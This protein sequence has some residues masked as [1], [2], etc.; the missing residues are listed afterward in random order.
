MANKVLAPLQ[1]TPAADGFAQC[2]LVLQDISSNLGL[3]ANLAYQLSLQ[4]GNQFIGNPSLAAS[5]AQGSIIQGDPR[6][7]PQLLAKGVVIDGSLATKQAL[8][9]V[10]TGFSCL[11]TL[12]IL[13]GA[14][15]S[16]ATLSI[17]FGF[18]AGATDVIA[19]AV[20]AGLTGPTLAK[21]L[22]PIAAGFTIGTTG[23]VLG[24]IATVQQASNLT[25]DVV[26]YL[27]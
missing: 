14:S 7:T 16:L 10:P 2:Q 20:H 5:I 8:Y 13:R 26:G 25:I 15:V 12:F 24:V 9:T 17:A 27:F 11:P 23:Q 19:T 4:F 18:N 6:G 3:S 21:Y 1:V 22:T